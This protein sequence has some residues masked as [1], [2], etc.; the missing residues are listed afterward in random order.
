MPIVELTA[1]KFIVRLSN[2]GAIRESDEDFNIKVTLILKS[3]VL[4]SLT[5]ARTTSESLVMCCMLK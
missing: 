1:L 3:Y 2:Y 4:L 5:V